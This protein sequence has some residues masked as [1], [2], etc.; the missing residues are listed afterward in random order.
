MSVKEQRILLVNPYGIGDVLFTTPVLQILKNQLPDAMI[1]YL[2]NERVAS[3]LRDCA[4]IDKIFIFE[5]DHLKSL[6]RENRKKCLAKF[7]FLLAQ[8]KSAKF[9]LALD[10]S[11][12][13]KFGFFLALLGIPRRIGF[14]YRNRGLFLTE[15]IPLKESSGQHRVSFYCQILTRLGLPFDSI[16]RI[17]LPLVDSDREGC[18]EFLR[19]QGIQA[20]ER[21]ICLHPG[22]GLTWGSNA[23]YKRWPAEHFVHLA[24]LLEQSFRVK[25]LILGSEAEMDLAKSVS[26]GIG[27]SAINICGQLD[28]RQLAAVFCASWFAICNDGGPLHLAVSQGTRTIS[29]FGPVDESVYGPFP[30]EGHLVFTLPVECRPCYRDFRFPSCPFEHRCLRD[31]GPEEVFE[32]IRLEFQ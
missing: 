32:G 22:G 29:F 4:L 30:R 17:S 26:D 2:C 13:R 14:N 11:L 18:R 25:F 6:W 21:F 19:L 8:V 28:L 15:K 16:P 9:E 31:L 1:G 3:L 5:K 10:Y 20:G 7:S 12:S 24:Q 23:R 27:P